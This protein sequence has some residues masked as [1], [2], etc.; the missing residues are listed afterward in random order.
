MGVNTIETRPAVK[1]E[2]LRMTK[3]NNSLIKA[4]KKP[5]DIGLIVTIFI[6]V[7]LGLIMVLSASAPSALTYEG[8][9]YYYFRSQLANAFVGIC[10]MI[11]FSLVN[12]KI[13]KGRIAKIAIVVAIG[14]LALVLVPGIGVTVK[15][16]T[17]WINVGFTFQPSELMKI[18]LIIYLAASLSKDPKKNKKFWKGIFPNLVVIRN[19]LFVII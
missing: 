7:S 12:Y 17:R 10:G 9:S 13:Y 14:L 2:E 16:A 8:D 5:L 4:K 6:L 1:K 11:F 18:A 19:Y 15:G 3:V